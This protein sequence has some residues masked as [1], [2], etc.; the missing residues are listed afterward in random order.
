MLV[1]STERRNRSL[2]FTAPSNVVK[3]KSPERYVLSVEL[4]VVRFMF[5]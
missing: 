4:C 3:S 5:R 2:S 1:V